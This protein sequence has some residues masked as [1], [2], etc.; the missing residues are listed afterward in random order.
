MEKGGNL[1][2]VIVEVSRLEV[3]LNPISKQSIACKIVHHYVRPDLIKLI[4]GH[5]CGVIS[6][7]MGP[8]NTLNCFINNSG[9]TPCL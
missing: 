5:K 7:F 3:K 9:G 8:K 6:D 2:N 4:K 1:P